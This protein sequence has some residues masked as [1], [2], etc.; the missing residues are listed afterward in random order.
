MLLPYLAVFE[1]FTAV[2]IYAMIVGMLCSDVV[3]YQHLSRPP[4]C[5]YPADGMPNLELTVSWI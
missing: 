1:V 3:G 4:E 5:R 2:K